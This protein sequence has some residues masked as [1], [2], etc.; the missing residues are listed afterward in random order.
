M[1]GREAPSSA[2]VE[3]LTAI[4]GRGR[5]TSSSSR[6]EGIPARLAV[7]GTVDSGHVKS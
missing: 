7:F 2:P 5:E 3:L 6:A 4:R 1:G